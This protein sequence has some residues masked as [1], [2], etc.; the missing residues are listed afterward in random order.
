MAMLIASSDQYN[1]LP[2]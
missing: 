2:Y 1:S